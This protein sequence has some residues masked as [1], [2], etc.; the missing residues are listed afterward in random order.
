MVSSVVGHV[1]PRRRERVVPRLSVNSLS[2][3]QTLRRRQR[4]VFPQNPRI[5]RFKTNFHVPDLI[6]IDNITYVKSISCV[7][8]TSLPIVEQLS[9]RH[10]K[11]HCQLLNAGNNR[12]PPTPPDVADIGTVDTGAVGIVLLAPALGL[13]I[14]SGNIFASG[15]FLRLQNCRRFLPYS[16]AGAMVH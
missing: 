2:G 10:A 16:S 9:G 7:I 11:R 6:R 15:K 14:C 12:V 1:N 5:S 3:A 13:A 4:G 8:A